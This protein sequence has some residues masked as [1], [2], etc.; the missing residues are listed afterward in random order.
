[1]QSVLNQE[2][3]DWELVLIDD[4]STDESAAMVTYFSDQDNRIRGLFQT[5]NSGAAKARN[6]G[7]LAARGRYIAFL[8]A[9]DTW[10]VEKLK[11][12]ISFMQDHAVALCYSGFWRKKALQCHQ[13]RV[14]KTVT[15]KQLL[16]G[17]TIGCLTAIYDRHYFGTVKM[18]DLP[19]R[20]DYALW[21]ELLSRVPEARG[22]DQPLAT[23][24]CQSQSLSSNRIKALWATWRLYRNYL[25]LS[26]IAS[27][28]F[29]FNN[30]AR[31]LLR[32]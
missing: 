8:D 10:A 3:T 22:I 19:L 31:R 2:F 23:Y 9:D 6:R 15:R 5:M 20:Q 18:P 14:P 16:R 30:L 13:V 17:N 26:H 25:G 4:G 7:I 11:S 12:Q 21:L 32:G 24:H 28:W 29:F 27:S 1:M